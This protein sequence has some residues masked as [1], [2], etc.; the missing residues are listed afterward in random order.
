M[1]TGGQR[2]G[3]PHD[4]TEVYVLSIFPPGRVLQCLD[5]PVGV[6]G[7][8]LRE[9]FGCAFPQADD[10][11]PESED[12]ENPESCQNSD[13]KVQREMKYVFRGL[14]G[15]QSSA[16]DPDRDKKGKAVEQGP[17]NAHRKLKLDVVRS[18]MSLHVIGEG[19]I[20][21]PPV[22]GDVEDDEEEEE[23]REEN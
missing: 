17:E 3:D 22:A 4:H 11:P 20:N 6:S 2:G 8:S 21:G 16:N 1:K 14:C 18:F 23:E 7:S 13:Y 9:L 5:C 15:C 19:R 10:P 12:E